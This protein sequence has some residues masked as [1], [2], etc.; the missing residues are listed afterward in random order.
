MKHEPV[1]GVQPEIFRWARQTIGL[2]VDDVARILKRS[3]DEIE[4][5]E[6]GK[7]APSYA[8]LEKLAYQVYK[9]PLAIFFLPAPPDEITPKRE[10]RTL[11]DSDLQ[12]L[13]P[14]TYLQIRRAHAYQLAL[15][16]LFNGRNPVDQPIWQMLTLTLGEPIE[17]QANSIRIF[18]G[19]DIESQIA[20]SS[21]DISLKNWRKKIEEVGV[22]V[23]K[24]S[25]KQKE[26]SGFCLRDD[27]LP[28]IY[29]NNST[30]KTR[31]IFSLLHELAHLLMDM[32]GLS[33]FDTDY[34]DRL[35]SQEKVIERFCNAIAAEVLIPSTDF[36]QQTNHFPFEVDQISD[37]DYSGL[38]SRYG[39]SREAILR[40]FLD[41]GRVNKAIYEQKAKFWK[42]QKK[43][44]SGGDWY[45]SQNVYLS[46]RFASEVISRHY[47]QQLTIDQ[48]AEFLGVKV[49]NFAGL[50]QRILQG[51]G[52]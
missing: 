15:D 49:K 37:E 19:I 9:R 40:R 23:F 20:W 42:R 3:A 5:W 14:D 22:F 38:A 28:I 7:K 50:E 16:E 51:A 13:L 18:L 48:A 36:V 33:K 47:R 2:S 29:L 11:P 34:I 43:I 46:H 45:A 12:T 21:D 10:F 44:S 41:Q 25:F 1:V 26:I 17:K 39:V 4:A 8:Q 35:P 32:N 24:N 6:L 31:Q 30:T 27:N 52:A